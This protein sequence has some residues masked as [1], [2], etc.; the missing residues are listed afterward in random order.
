MGLCFPVGFQTNRK[1]LWLLGELLCVCGSSITKRLIPD[2]RPHLSLPVCGQK[3]IN[4]LKC[5]VK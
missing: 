2:K 1:F 4:A 5:R 3:G